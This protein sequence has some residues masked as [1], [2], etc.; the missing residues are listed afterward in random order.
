MIKDNTAEGQPGHKMA[1]FLRKGK[2]LGEKRPGR[3]SYTYTPCFAYQ[4]R[5]STTSKIASVDLVVAVHT[6][7]PM[8]AC[9]GRV[10]KRAVAIPLDIQLLFCCSSP[11]CRHAP[12]YIALFYGQK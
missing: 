11:S 10:L 5:S 6:D 7:L 9:G 2:C 1:S 3:M 12:F 8:E 4:F